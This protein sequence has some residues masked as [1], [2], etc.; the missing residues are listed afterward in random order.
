[1]ERPCGR[2]TDGRT[3]W[4]GRPWSKG[5]AGERFVRIVVPP[6]DIVPSP[7]WSCAMLDEGVMWSI[8]ENGD[9]IAAEVMRAGARHIALEGALTW[10][11]PRVA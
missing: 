9:Y 8:L 10:P 3:G 1:M 4:R 7:P 11:C 5:E 2:L 6:P